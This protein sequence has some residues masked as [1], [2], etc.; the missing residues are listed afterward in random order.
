MKEWQSK[1][2]ICDKVFGY[3]ASP[4]FPLIIIDMIWTFTSFRCE[5]CTSRGLPR[6]RTCYSTSTWSWALPAAPD[7]CS[8]QKTW[9]GW[10]RGPHTR[11]SPPPA[12][13]SVSVGVLLTD[14]KNWRLC[15]FKFDK[16]FTAQAKGALI[17]KWNRHFL[18]SDTIIVHVNR[19][20]I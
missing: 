6:Q 9:T 18:K 17:W 8:D 1:I 7:A 5:L 3:R 12:L 15:Y 4:I 13:E 16:P 14:W 2:A 20:F 19:N 10:R 11:G